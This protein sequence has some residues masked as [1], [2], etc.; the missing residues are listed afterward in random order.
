MLLPQHSRQSE[1]RAAVCAS[2]EAFRAA[3]AWT[4]SIVSIL[5]PV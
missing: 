1:N 3:H 4:S 5:I 2:Y